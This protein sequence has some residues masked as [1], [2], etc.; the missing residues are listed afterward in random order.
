MYT[1]RERRYEFRNEAKSL[2]NLVLG[3]VNKIC[4]Y[5]YMGDFNLEEGAP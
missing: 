2:L 4:H 1:F 3:S 5:S